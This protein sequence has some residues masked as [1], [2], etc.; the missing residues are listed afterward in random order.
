MIPARLEAKRFPRKPLARLGGRP[1]VEWVYE[2]CARH[3][4]F[5]DVI[6]A[7][8]SD[9]IEACVRGF[10]GS[11]ELTRS[12]H[13]TG[14]DRV[15]E[16]AA[17]RPEADVV[18]NVQADQPFVTSTTLERLLTPYEAGDPPEMATVACPLDPERVADPNVVKVVCDRAGFALY[19]SRSPIPHSPE[20]TAPYL[21]HLGLYAFTGEFLQRY[22]HLPETVLERSER[23]E[24][25]RALEHGH[26]IAVSLTEN[27][28]L[29]VNR[30]EDLTAAEAL[31]RV[32][33][34]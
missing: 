1:L 22:A 31:L 25:L 26:R 29:E 34:L 16:V 33:R 12:D 30:V 2:A 3:R 14:T 11:A 7:T 10:G 5:D 4:G 15:A 24:Q 19:F 9:E 27:P 21:H 32:S 28:V 6:V 17:R 8:D 23:L 13:R 20:G 18:A